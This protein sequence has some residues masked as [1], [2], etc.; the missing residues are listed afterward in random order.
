ME[1]KNYEINANTQLVALGDTVRAFW[2]PKII[3]V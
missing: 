2:D 3:W 1:D